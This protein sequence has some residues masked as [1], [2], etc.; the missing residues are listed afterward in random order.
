MR[1]LFIAHRTPYPPNKGEKIRAFWELQVLAKR[2]EVDLFCFYDDAEDKEYAHQLNQYCRQYYLE[3]LSYFRSRARAVFALLLGQPFSTGFFYSRTMARQIKTALDLRSYDKIFVFS[4]SVAQYVEDSEGVPKVLDMVD[5]DSDK[6]EQYANRSRWPLAWLW[7]HE[8]R[9][10]AAYESFLVRQFSTSVVC[11]NAEAELLRSKA[12]VGE[13]Q[14]L[15]NF[16]DV[17]QYDPQQIPLPEQIRSWQ[18]Y[19]IF[20]GSM[21]YFPNMDAAGYFYREI[22]PLIRRELPSTRFVIAGRNPHR[23][24]A[25][26]GSDPAVQ[27]TGSVADMKP[28][29]CGAA[30]AIVPMRIARGVQNKILEALAGGIP[31][32]ST[33]A[34]ASALPKDLRSLLTIADTP[35]EFAAA[36]VKVL[37]YGSAIRSNDRRTALKNHYERLD[38]ASQ[39]ESLI[40]HPSAA[41][42]VAL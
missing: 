7:R 28:Y 23:S 30:A 42:A 15:E 31:V 29:I 13:I 5:V 3:K 25:E 27:I 36:V 33:A 21:D 20:S 40:L 10:L 12:P 37:R 39:L 19:V 38:L 1:I 9:S 34:A 35:Q 32:V 18:P 2:H 41:E 4:S 17:D 11:T 16:L 22:F 26:L 24:I 8:A 14:V 6:W